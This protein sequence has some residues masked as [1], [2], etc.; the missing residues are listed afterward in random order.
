[1]G[2][3]KASFYIEEGG[4]PACAVRAGGRGRYSSTTLEAFISAHGYGGIRIMCKQMRLVH[5]G[6]L[7]FSADVGQ[8]GLFQCWTFPCTAFRPS[9]LDPIISGGALLSY[10]IDQKV[11]LTSHTNTMAVRS[12]SPVAND[13]FCCNIIL[14]HHKQQQ[15][16]F[17]LQSCF[18]IQ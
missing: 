5:L 6:I 3:C 2:T 11:N 15:I 12:W 4:C 13:V 7:L 1:M 9:T 18:V 10:A 14:P 16:F 8:R 17:L